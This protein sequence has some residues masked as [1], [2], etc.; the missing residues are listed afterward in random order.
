MDRGC[1]RAAKHPR[2]V[3]PQS[4]HKPIGSMKYN[5]ESLE[6]EGGR[7]SGKECMIRKKPRRTG[8]IARDSPDSDRGSEAARPRG[9]RGEGRRGMR[10]DLLPFVLNASNKWI[11]TRFSCGAIARCLA[12]ALLSGANRT[13]DSSVFQNRCSD[14]DYPLFQPDRCRDTKRKSFG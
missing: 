4:W 9:T 5:S 1:A 8:Q 12:F 2:D 7:C 10:R 14:R 6:E 13:K 3:A 11:G